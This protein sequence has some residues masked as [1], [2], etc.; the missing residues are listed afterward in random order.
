MRE[1]PT[2]CA[3]FCQRFLKCV[4]GEQ[5]WNSKHLVEPIRDFV[6]PSDEAFV[7]LVLENNCSVWVDMWDKDNMKESNVVPLWTNGGQNK[8]DRN[9]GSTGKHKGWSN[10]GVNRFNQLMVG[11]MRNRKNFPNFDTDLLQK[12]QEERQE[13]GKK[14][15]H[16][17]TDETPE[18]EPLTDFQW[19]ER[20]QIIAFQLKHHNQR[21]VEGASDNSDNSD[22]EEDDDDDDNESEGG[23][24]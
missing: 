15:K 11:V 14:K 16:K 24:N 23:E 5:K 19:D 10:E 9:N 1:R 12:W 8:K 6:T 21:I 22:D 18:V 4:V 20:C 2:F 3:Q 7:I 13:N 17:K